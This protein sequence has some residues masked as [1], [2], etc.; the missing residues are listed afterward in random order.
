VASCPPTALRPVL[1][2]FVAGSS[3]WSRLTRFV[4]ALM[5]A[6]LFLAW[7]FVGRQ[8]GFGVFQPVEAG[9]FAMVFL[10]ATA[11]MS[12]DPRFRTGGGWVA[13]ASSAIPLVVV[14]ILAGLLVFVPLFRSD[15]SPALIMVLLFAGILAAFGAVVTLRN[16]G[17]Q[18]DAH[19]QRQ[20]VPRV[21]KPAFSRF[22][23]VKRTWFYGLLLVSFVAIGGWFVAGSPI[24]S[25]FARVTG[26]Q[27]WKGDTQSRLL[28]LEGEGLGSARRVVVERVI[29]WLDLD[30]A[31]PELAS[32]SFSDKPPEAFDM[33]P[34]AP[35]ACYLDIEWQLIRSRRVIAKAPCGLADYLRTGPG[36]SEKAAVADNPV[37]AILHRVT[38]LLGERSICDVERTTESSGSKDKPRKE[39]R[40]IDIPVVESDFAGS[41]LIGRLGAAAGLLLYG[42]QA[43]LLIIVAIGFVR[44]SWTPSSGQ[45]D[46]AVRRYIAI[47]LAGAAWLLLLQWSLS[48]SNMLGL[49][50]VMGQPMTWLSYATS[51]H[52]FMAVP[53]ILV[54]VIG[55]RY[56]GMPSYRYTPRDPPQTR[57]NPWYLW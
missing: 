38:T 51:H 26:V 40:P 53:C 32:C 17:D 25:T 45:L 49:L 1:Q 54:F 4:P 47:V 41:Y 9:K 44:V 11:L 24:A 20:R 52:L 22:W 56:A 14:L 36:V 33:L 50:P 10:V 23:L 29:S 46:E 18:L 42:A 8:T 27:T 6:L 30:F 48:W 2:G 3:G 34:R 37:N 5:L 7:F 15:W 12:L 43:L 31:R 35:R 19:Y 55:L 13:L 57:Y 21:F 16:I 28:D 39:V